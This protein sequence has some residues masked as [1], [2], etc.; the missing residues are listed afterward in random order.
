MGDMLGFG[1]GNAQPQQQQTQVEEPSMRGRL[2]ESPVCTSKQF[3]KLWK[4]TKD[5][6]LTEQRTLSSEEAAAQ[7]EELANAA[8]FK[9][10]ASAPKG[11]KLKF[12]FYAQERESAQSLHF[13]ECNINLDSLSL[14][15]TV[16]GTSDLYAD[17]AQFFLYSVNRA[18]S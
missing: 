13:V 3:Q 4:G 17:V 18:L 2:K 1:G 11:R 8:N 6:V 14:K 10:M 15:L 9:T 7:F 5:R 12:Y 16:K